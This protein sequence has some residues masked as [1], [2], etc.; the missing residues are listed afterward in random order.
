MFNA[1][2]FEH[3]VCSD[4]HTKT[5]FFRVVLLFV[6]EDGNTNYIVCL[7][8]QALKLNSIQYLR[9][10]NCYGKATKKRISWHRET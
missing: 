7:S 4:S 8:F 3:I 9:F 5:I 1:R 2:A 10:T 6:P